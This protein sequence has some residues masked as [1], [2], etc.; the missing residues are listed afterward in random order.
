VEEDPMDRN[1]GLELIGHV[2]GN[3]LALAI[4]VGGEIDD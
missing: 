4:R 1:A 3:G 2:P